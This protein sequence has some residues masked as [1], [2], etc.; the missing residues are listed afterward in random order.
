MFSKAIPVFEVGKEK[1]MNTFYG[2]YA[3]ITEGS[4]TVLKIAGSSI[5]SV[6]INGEFVFS[7]PARAAHDHYR[8]DEIP[9]DSYLNNEENVL[10]VRLTSYN[11]NSFSLLDAPGF[12]CAEV[13]RGDEVVAYTDENGNG[14]FTCVELDERLQ[15]VLRYSY[16]RNFTESYRLDQRYNMFD[17]DPA[18]SG[19]RAVVLKDQGDK[20]F[21]PR[22]VFLPLFE[23]EYPQSIIAQGRVEAVVD[24]P[25]HRE[26]QHRKTAIF[27]CFEEEELEYRC[28]DEARSMSFVPE[29]ESL[30][31]WQPVT[32]SAGRYA[33][34]A[35][36]CNLTGFIDM[37]VTVD[38]DAELIL[39]FDEVYN[40]NNVNYL[41]LQCANIV[42]YDLKAGKYHVITQEPYTF[43]YM[44]AA[45]RIGSVTIEA[46]NVRRASFPSIENRPSIEDPELSRIYDAAIE[47]FRQNTYDIYM[48]C[49]SR[50]RAGWLCDS[51]FSSRVERYLT[52]KTEV[53]QNFLNNYLDHEKDAHVPDGM[54]SM[55]YPADHTTGEYIPNWAMWF[56]LELE[57]Y[58]SFAGDRSLIDRAKKKVMDLLDFFRKFENSDGLLEKLESWVFVEWSRS[59]DLVQDVNFPSNMLYARMKRA[60]ASLYGDE[61]LVAEAEK[62]EDY[63]RK[64]TVVNGFFC[65]N[66]L[67]GEDGVLRLSGECTEACQ[68][69]AFFMNVA[70]PDS[71]PELWKILSEDFG[72]NRK[73]DNR[74]PDIAFANSFIGNY[75]RLDLLRR[76]GYYDK[77]LNEIR[78]YFLY[79]ADKTGTLWENDG[80]YASCNHGFASY[81]AVLI[82]EGMKS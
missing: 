42:T 41:R 70:T 43:K 33:D 72:P 10:T 5:Y 54:L 8:V 50:E 24:A 20:K 23:T 16:Q 31:D 13:V 45:S 46:L 79:M 67:R 74:Y 38:E 76:Y 55:C 15:K 22:S 59:N 2:F 12:L 53:E 4:E 26:R 56:V 37:M 80:D 7:G 81:I 1:E 32:L 36:R 40:N 69:Y 11:C 82:R 60:I 44:R 3:T 64:N 25:V 63:I 52:G 51:F 18:A 39:M 66:A 62:I 6:Y 48:D 47:T 9:I 78:G 19:H 30:R 28:I 57:E 17:L 21:I 68:Y 14:G 61:S 27:K 77:M 35:Y 34:I 71:H 75:L 29:N 49:P 58:L 73:Q 65:D